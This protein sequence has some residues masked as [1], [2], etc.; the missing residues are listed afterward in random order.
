[1]GKSMAEIQRI[2]NEVYRQ[3]NEDER[4]KFID[5]AE[6]QNVNP[7]EK[8]INKNAVIKRLRGDLHDIVNIFTLGPCLFTS[9]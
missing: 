9:F 5:D 8:M 2:A 6:V 1:M 7:S 4:K 3:L